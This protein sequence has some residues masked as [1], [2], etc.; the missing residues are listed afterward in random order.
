MNILN[1]KFPGEKYPPL[2]IHVYYFLVSCTFCYIYSQKFMPA[3]NFYGSCDGGGIYAVLQ[4]IACKPIQ[5]RILIPYIMKVLLL[6]HVLKDKLVFVLL[7]VVI[8][9]FILLT[10]YLILNCYFKSKAHNCWLAPIII[11][12]MMWNYII[13]NGQFFYMD[14]SILLIILLGFYFIITEQNIPMMILFVIGLFNH[15]SVG[16][17]IFAY[18][19]YNYKKLFTAKTIIYTVLMSVIYI[20]TYKILDD[21]YPR[22]GGYF[23]LFNMYRNLGLYKVLPFHIIARDAL[24]DYG[25]LHFFFLIFLF[26]GAWKRF[27]G[28]MLYINAVVFPYLLSVLISFSI[29][30][31]RNYITIIP[32]VVI[33]CLMYLSTFENSFLKPTEGLLKE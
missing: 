10:F 7:L 15:P 5:F 3:A 28:P 29:D 33:C 18:L 12:P 17:L 13:L 6:F 30:D 9:Y 16:Y 1:K 20:A 4:G 31:I 27:R 23:V 25:G 19:L 26:S 11:Y 8:T 24:F 14:F 21:I 22:E 32:F 2:V